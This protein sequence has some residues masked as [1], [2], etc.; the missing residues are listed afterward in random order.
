MKPFSSLLLPLDGSRTAARSLGVAL[1]LATR[2]DG[3]L[4]ILSATPH[5]RPA[6]EALERLKVPREAWPRI[7][8][9]QARQFPEEAVLDAASRVGADLLVM[10][11]RG[12]AAN[13][14]GQE[15][16]PFKLLGHVTRWIVEQSAVPVLVTPMRYRE[17]L[18]WTSALTPIS[19]EFESDSAL[20]VALRLAVALDFV[21][22]VV[23]VVGGGQEAAG[24]AAEARYADAPHHEYPQRLQQLVRRLLPECGAAECRR[25]TDVSLC[26]GDPG[27]E[28]LR[29]IE[30]HGTSLLV[31][32]WHGRF[33]R[34][35]AGVVKQL[36]AT[37][38]C[39]ILLVKAARPAPF[40]L[41][42]GGEIE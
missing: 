10:S 24:L 29:I 18:P 19:G 5:E 1:W 22:E 12:E 27:E 25:I 41:K 38:E 15:P 35:H 8:L 4:H 3:V 28:L 42:V 33:V 32:G 39:P 13:G 6:R 11:A 37:T 7:T 34:G 2:L 16:D 23:H 26:R 31:M 14:E 17:R 20:G 9:H 36:L 21:I 30:E 40:K